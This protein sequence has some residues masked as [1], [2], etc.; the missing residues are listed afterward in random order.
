M[1]VRYETHILIQWYYKIDLE[2]NLCEGSTPDKVRRLEYFPQNDRYSV[3]QAWGHQSLKGFPM[4]GGI[5]WMIQGLKKPRDGTWTAENF[6]V[7]LTRDLR[8]PMN[9]WTHK[10]V[11]EW[12]TKGINQAAQKKMASSP[13]PQLLK[14]W[15]VLHHRW[16]KAELRET[17]RTY[18][19]WTQ[20]WNLELPPGSPWP[21]LPSG[22]GPAPLLLSLCFLWAVESPSS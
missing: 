21:N 17:A 7:S 1:E 16:Q 9:K 13:L 6:G 19:C 4:K 3:L 18:Y 20:S 22:N 14:D 10:Q 5:C 15:K 11:N 12:M 2:K 8:S